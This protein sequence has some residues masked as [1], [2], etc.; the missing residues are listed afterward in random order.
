MYKEEKLDLLLRATLGDADGK[1]EIKRLD[2]KY[3]RA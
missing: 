3:P 2:K 1:G